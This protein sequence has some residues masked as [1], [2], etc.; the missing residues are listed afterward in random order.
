[1]ARSKPAGAVL[2]MDQVLAELAGQ[3]PDAVV[4]GTPSAVHRARVATRRIGA[5]MQV[6]HPLA[7]ESQWQLLGK[8]LK[9]NA[10]TQKFL[11]VLADNRR[12][13]ALPDIVRAFGAIAAAAPARWASLR[14]TSSGS[15]A[16]RSPSWGSRT[17]RASCTATSIRR[18]SSSARTITTCG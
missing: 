14:A 16:A 2:Y 4:R 9:L 5:A 7:Q 10:L 6:M 17:S 3:A 12:L 18:T 15:C 11:G 13:S 1:M 8:A